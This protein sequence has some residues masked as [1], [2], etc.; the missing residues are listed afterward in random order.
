MLIDTGAAVSLIDDRLNPAAVTVKG[1]HQERL[2][3]FEAYSIEM[4]LFHP[5]T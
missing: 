3:V 1:N 2:E 4:L 5:I